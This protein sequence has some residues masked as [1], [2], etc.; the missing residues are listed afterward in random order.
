MKGVI[1]VKV[2]VVKALRTLKSHQIKVTLLC[3][4]QTSLKPG[5]D[6]AGLSDHPLGIVTY[7][8]NYLTN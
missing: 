7:S 3:H 2:K 8:V 4:S 5:H 1:L 6:M